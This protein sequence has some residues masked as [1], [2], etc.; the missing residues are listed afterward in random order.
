MKKL[1]AYID[2]S[3]QPDVDDFVAVSGVW[4][5]RKCIK[6]AGVFL[7]RLRDLN[8]CQNSIHFCE[9][10]ELK[11]C[12]GKAHLGLDWIRAALDDSELRLRV[13]TLLVDCRSFEMHWYGNS[14]ERAINKLVK[15][16]MLGS[17]ALYCD[18]TDEID[19]VIA[20]DG[21]KACFKVNTGLIDYL[22][23][24]IRYASRIRGPQPNVKAI[25]VK[26]ISRKPLNV[27]GTA[28]RRQD[29]V[30]LADVVA[31]AVRLHAE[32]LGHLDRR[33]AKRIIAEKLH[34]GIRRYSKIPIAQRP[35][36]VMMYTP[37][38][39]FETLVPVETSIRVRR[40]QRGLSMN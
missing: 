40:Y 23:R 4:C 30:A 38:N 20:V 5:E 37:P 15:T 26:A 34:K 13:R 36:E 29:L 32:G 31:G 24:E 22:R 14:R 16:Y 8:R 21:H 1:A 18:S 27:R 19:L 2:V 25:Q 17:L 12:G 7:Q 28:R 35:V 6:N 39:V 9:L 3:G 33:S 11:S 10:A